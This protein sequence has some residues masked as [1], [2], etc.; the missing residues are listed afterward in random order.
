MTER[1]SVTRF[2]KDLIPHDPDWTRW[3]MAHVLRR[4]A[5]ENG[6]GLFLIAPEEG[7]AQWTYAEALED[8]ERVGGGLRA[9]GVQPG[10]RVI[11]MAKNSSRFVMTWLGTAMADIVQAPVNTAYEGD[12][13]RH[14]VTLVDAEWVVCDD[15][16]ADRF[17]AIA[18]QIEGQEV[19]V[20]DNGDLDGAPRR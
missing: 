14:Q 9:D 1:Y 13:L 11:I 7:E 2:Y 19:L 20:I 10:D 16:F 5:A 18:A 12:F 4:Q 17:I 8:A 3:T 6:E 15:S